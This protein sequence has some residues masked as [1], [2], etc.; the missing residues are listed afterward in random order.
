M[1]RRFRKQNRRKTNGLDFQKLEPRQLLAGDFMGGHQVAGELPTQANI[2]ANGDFENVTAGADNFYTENEVDAWSVKDA[3]SGHELNLFT[4][5]D[6]HGL[7]LDLDSTVADFDRVYQDVPIESN[8]NYLITF[9]YRAHPSDNPL[10]TQFTHDFEV[11]WGGVRVGRFTGGVEW[12]TGIINVGAFEGDP[13]HGQTAELLFC[14]I[15]EDGAPGGDGMGALLDNIRI[16]EV[17]EVA[18]SNHGFETTAEDRTL[19]YRPQ[20]VVGWSAMGAEI[21]DR[22]LK[23][24]ESDGGIPDATEGNQ[25]LNLDATDA[26][27]DIIFRDIQTTPGSSYYITFDYRTDGDIVANPDE[28][29]VRWNNTW[30]GTFKGMNQWQ[31]VGM[32]LTAA[33]SETRL[34]FLEPGETTGDGSGPLIDNVRMFQITEPVDVSDGTIRADI[35]GDEEGVD[36]NATYVP[37]AGSQPIGQQIRLTRESSAD[38]TSA[39]VT[40]GGAVDGAKETLWVSKILPPTDP[41][42]QPIETKITI[43]AYDSGTHQLY[44]SGKASIAEYQQ[45]LNTL[46]YHN[47][48]T[49]VSTSNRTITV[50]IFDS[51]LPIEKSTAFANIDLA[52]ETDQATIDDTILKKYI[53]DN[54][55]DAYEVEP[56]LYA[57]V[58]ALGSGQNPTINSTVRVKY[59]GYLLRLTDANDLV[60]GV[61]FDFSSDDGTT[62][63]LSN[64]IRGWQLGIPEYKTGGYGQLL[65][66]SALA[67]GE[68][69]FGSEIPPNSVLIFDVEL[70]QIVS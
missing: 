2:V 4:S 25:Y 45:V 63:P 64:V 44:L 49:D 1:K 16:V 65:I 29:R 50:S 38:L 19:F 12:Q 11:W 14:E 17:D 62:F 57:V 23:I 27:R 58:D 67:Y 9:D 69:G 34:T 59:S 47:A 33:S 56:G 10:A 3:E 13:A 39:V 40:L 6:G 5:L 20:D 18:L 51:Q 54:E 21:T 32:M 15:P 36:G 42:D 55:L 43:L 48:A 66:S 22:W 31:S 60:K 28:L 24:V 26:T 7:V 61:N 8:A 37:G 30:A 46:S 35:N 68:G 41:A 52:I 70:K 53:A